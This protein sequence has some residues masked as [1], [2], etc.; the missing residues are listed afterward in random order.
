M[1]ARLTKL[2][3]SSLMLVLLGMMGAAAVSGC[4]QQ[5]GEQGAD[6]PAATPPAQ[7]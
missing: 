6:Q 4:E 5:P 3:L 1:S 2:R 7:Q